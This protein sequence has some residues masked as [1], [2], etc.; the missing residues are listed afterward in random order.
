LTKLAKPPLLLPVLRARP[1][2]LRPLLHHSRATDTVAPIVAVLIAGLRLP[3]RWVLAGPLQS[4]ELPSSHAPEQSAPS[5]PSSPCRSSPHVPCILI[6]RSS[7]RRC[8]PTRARPAP[9]ISFVGC[10]MPLLLSVVAR[11]PLGAVQ[12]R[13]PRELGR[14]AVCVSSRRFFGCLC[15]GVTPV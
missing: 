4:G 10:Q 6:C 8:S 5:P 9:I 14:A 3:E 15:C 2:E 1:S 7:Q 11:R 13:L 12:R